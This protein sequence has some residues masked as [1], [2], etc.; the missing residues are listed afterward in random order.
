MSMEF[1]ITEGLPAAGIVSLNEAKQRLG[2]SWTSSA[3]D[4]EIT[5]L[6][7]AAE[8]KFEYDTRRIYATREVDLTCT[9]PYGA[10]L[11]LPVS[12]VKL[13]T[14]ID[15][16]DTAGAEQEWAADQ[17][18]VDYKFDRARVRPRPGIAW[19]NVMCCTPGAFRIALEAGYDDDQPEYELAR[20]AVLMLVQHWYDH[21]IVSSERVNAV[22]MAYETIMW[23]LMS[24]SA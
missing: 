1:Q 19:P 11:E 7:K 5:G 6:I 22:P 4:A 23:N 21:N 14:A 18:A 13:V 17:W 3:L 10:F 12:P 16:T 20:T 24:P 2:V 9:K 15:Y 8:R